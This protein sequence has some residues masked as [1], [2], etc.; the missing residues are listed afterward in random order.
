MISG[1][2]LLCL[3][4]QEIT[5]DY[6]YTSTRWDLLYVAAVIHNTLL[7]LCFEHNAIKPLYYHTTH[8]ITNPLSTDR[9]TMV[10]R[11]LD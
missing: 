1:C 3:H 9:H 5:K 2:T 4:H 8:I 7:L 10:C 6:H 11:L